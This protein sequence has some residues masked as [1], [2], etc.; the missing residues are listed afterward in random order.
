MLSKIILK[1]NVL[2]KRSLDLF[3]LSIK[4]YI[5]LYKYIE[6]LQVGDLMMIIL[7]SSSDVEHR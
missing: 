4:K 2:D 7:D 1:K 5:K 6:L 3:K